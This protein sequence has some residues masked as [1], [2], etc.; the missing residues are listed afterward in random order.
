MK[1][2]G[3][4]IEVF[5]PYTWLPSYGETSV[6]FRIENSELVVTIIFDGESGICERELRFVAVC[7]FC[8]QAF[9]GPSMLDID[10]DDVKLLLRGV[11]IEYPNSE[12]A[13]AWRV[14]FGSARAVRHFSIA[15]MSANI[16]FSVL[17]SEVMVS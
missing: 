13:M 4:G 16:K 1:K 8:S 3:K 11:L 9:P 15:F 5:N 6:K 14:H 10:G 7:W 2:V 12:A 17:A